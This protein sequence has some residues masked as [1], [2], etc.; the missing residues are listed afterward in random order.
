M[1]IFASGSSLGRVMSTF[2]AAI[3][4]RSGALERRSPMGRPVR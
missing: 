2:L 3:L 4:R 1:P